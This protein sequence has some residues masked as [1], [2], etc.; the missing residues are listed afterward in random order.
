MEEEEDK[1]VGDKEVA[2]LI[3]KGEEIIPSE[4]EAE[5]Q[6]KEAKEEGFESLVREEDCEVFYRPDL[7]KDTATTS[8]S[9]AVTVS[10]DQKA[11]EMP[12]G[13]GGEVAETEPKRR[14]RIPHWNPPLVLDGAPLTSD[15]SIRNFDKKRVSYIANSV[16][17]ALMLPLDMAELHNL[18]KHGMFLSLKRDLALV[19]T[20][21]I[22]L[23]IICIA[24]KG[25][26]AF[27]KSSE[28]QAQKQLHH[29]KEAED[30]LDLARVKIWELTKKLGQKANNIAKVEDPEKV[31]YP[32][33]IRVKVAAPIT[34]STVP[35]ASLA[36]DETSSPTPSDK[37]PTAPLTS[38][39]K[40]GPNQDKAIPDA[41][42]PLLTGRPP[43]WPRRTTN[44]WTRGKSWE[45]R[46]K[47]TLPLK[48]NLL[49]GPKYPT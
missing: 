35:S 20:P 29:M 49:D 47:I 7:T 15:S 30:Q 34:S 16:E 26:E 14:P 44:R 19:C 48:L 45:S 18:K 3:A 23:A 36:S 37:T 33:A 21:P 2:Q 24:Q 28:R 39:E 27:I 1:H 38:S 13:M 11:I 25:I 4:D 6:S 32:L 10:T 40:E 43:K 5:V 41:P 42:N 17:Q 9:I 46:T 12:K 22:F 8:T 31:F